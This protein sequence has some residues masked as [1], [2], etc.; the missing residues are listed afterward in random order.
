MDHNGAKEFV[1]ARGT[2]VHGVVTSEC[3]VTVSGVLDGELTAPALSVTESGIVSGKVKV[4]DLRSS[5]E[6]A[7]EIEAGTMQLSGTVRDKTLIRARSLDVKLSADGS[8]TLQL[9][10]GTATLEVG[11]NPTDI[12]APEPFK[13]PA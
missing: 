5:G 11:P 9:V 8:D 1:V 6:I 4:E 2:S 10:F 13:V 12:Y 3:P 7:G